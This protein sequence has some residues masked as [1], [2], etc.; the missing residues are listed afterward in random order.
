MDEKDKK[1][2]EVLKADSRKSFRKLGKIFGVSDVAAK[3]RVEKLKNEGVIS[4][5]S[6]DVDPTKIGYPLLATIGVQVDPQKLEEV[7]KEMMKFNEFFSVW[8]VTGA[9]NLH[10]RGAFRDHTHMNSVLE[11]ALSKEGIREYHLSL[12]SEELKHEWNYST[13]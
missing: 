10:I 4:R 1:I 8:K 5:F 9:H 3:N 2:L 13:K 11:E 7:G 12:M 6:V